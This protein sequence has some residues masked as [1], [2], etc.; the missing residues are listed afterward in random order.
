[1][2]RDSMPRPRPAQAGQTILE[3]LRG[4]YTGPGG[5]DAPSTTGPPEPPRALAERLLAELQARGV[6]VE[7]AARRRV[8]GCR[9]RAQLERWL[10]R[11]ADGLSIFEEEAT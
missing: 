10:R 7:G 4:E 3:Q 6:T 2:D 8:L 11:A 1:M 9:D 5:A